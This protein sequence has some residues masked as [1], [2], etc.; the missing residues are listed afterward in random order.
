MSKLEPNMIHRTRLAIVSLVALL[1]VGLV[2]S[3]EDITMTVER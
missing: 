1:I 2:G 3:A